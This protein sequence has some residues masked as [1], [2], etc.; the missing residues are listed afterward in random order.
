MTN[1]AKKESIKFIINSIKPNLCDYSDACIPMTGDI[2]VTDGGAGQAAFKICA[3]FSDG[4]T[5][6]NDVLVDLSNY[7]YIYIYIYIYYIYIY[8]LYIHYI[9]IYIYIYKLQSVC[10]I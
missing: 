5:N 3:L 6:R 10:I 4:K 8:I 9:Y 7:I 1:S 2:L